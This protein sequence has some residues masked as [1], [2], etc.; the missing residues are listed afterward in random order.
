MCPAQCNSIHFL[1]PGC[2]AS[3]YCQLGY[4]VDCISLNALSC[5]VLGWSQTKLN[6]LGKEE[7]KQQPL[8]YSEV[9]HLLKVVRER[10]SVLADS[11]FSTW[12]NRVR[13]HILKKKERK[14]K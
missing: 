2:S 12:G 1:H 7:V 9:Y 14:E 3:F 11:S 6:D 4:A 5:K 8:L 13:L 10:Y